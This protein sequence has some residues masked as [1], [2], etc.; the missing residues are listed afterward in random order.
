MKN[1][2]A[3]AVLYVATEVSFDDRRAQWLGQEQAKIESKGSRSYRFVS[4]IFYYEPETT[5]APEAA[6]PIPGFENEIL[7]RNK[8]WK[9]YAIEKPVDLSFEH[10]AVGKQGF[11]T[12]SPANKNPEELKPISE[13][14]N[15]PAV[16]PNKP[17]VDP[18]KPKTDQAFWP[19]DN[20]R[21]QTGF[22][23]SAKPPS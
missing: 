19:A 11:W 16:G 21:T 2:S 13:S 8:D 3:R 4:K 20:I 15:K 1:D 18:N 17:A 22:R 9:S 23:K 6:I 12:T 10:K 14:P 5:P 7:F